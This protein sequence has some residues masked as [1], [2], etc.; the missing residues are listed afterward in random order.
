MRIALLGAGRIGQLHGRLV[1]AQ[2][3]VDEVIVNDVDPERARVVAEACGGR[4]A[5]TV[6]EALGAADAVLIAA[7][8]N[9]HAELVRRSIDAGLPIFVEKP[10]AFDLEETVAVVAKAEAAGAAVQVGFQR[11]FDPAYVEAKRLLDSGELGTVYLVR[12]IAHDHRPPPEAYIAVSGGLFRD[13][14]IHDFDILRWLTGQEVAEV[15]ATGAVRNFPEFGR[16][17]DIDTGAVILTLADGTIGTLG[18]N[19]QNPRGYDVRMEVV[20]SKDVVAVGL[21]QGTPV[22][23]LDGDAPPLAGPPWDSHLDRFEAAYRAELLAFLR[24]ARGEIPS[25]CTARD[26]LQAMRIAV[27]ATRSRSEHRPVRLDEVA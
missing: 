26:G 16:H 11:R 18:Q 10:L 22:A 24:V 12:L 5:A 19:R 23:F 4:A 8:T 2:E 7:S 17:D 9:A 3:G 13:S 20:G 15:Y 6:D 21:N 25:P 14:S 1:A 27:A